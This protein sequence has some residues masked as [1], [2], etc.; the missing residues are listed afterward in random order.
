MNAEAFF[1]ALADKPFEHDFFSA[2]RRIECLHPDKPRIG[3]ALRPADEPLRFAQ[4]ASLAFAPAALASFEHAQ[5]K[6]PPRLQ[7]CFFGLLGP[8]GPLPLHLTE[9]A[10]DRLLHGGDRTFP[11]FLDVI[12]HRFIALFY[13]AWSQAQ[14]T[15]SLDRPGDDRAAIYLGSLIGIGAP[16]IRDR[17][18]V[19]DFAKLFHAGLLV[20]HVRNR[21]GLAALLESFFRVRVHIEEFVGHWMTLPRNELTRIG[22]MRV[23][24]ALGRG[25]LLGARVWDRQHKFRIRLGPLGL[26]RYESFLPEGSSIGRLAAWVRHYLCHELVW[27][28]RLVLDRTEVPQTKLGKFGRLGWTTWLGVFSRPSDAEDLVMDVEQLL[29]RGTRAR[30]ERTAIDIATYE[31]AAA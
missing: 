7:V 3:E 29:R 30:F 25:A 1:R 21:E 6:V 23:S 15:A 17:D 19:P 18:A 2:V 11:R 20:R 26:A 4:D 8:N 16:R 12:H 9:Y 24:A 10:R 13:R 28:V 31:R 14:L 5:G 27:D 22:S